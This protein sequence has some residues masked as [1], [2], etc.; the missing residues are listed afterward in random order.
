MRANRTT[1]PTV[2]V[3][4]PT[5]NEAEN[6][7][8]VLPRIPDVHEVIVVDGHSTDGS[9]EVARAVRPSARV[10]QQT[11]RGKGNAMACGFTAATGQVLVM[12]DADGSAD[13]DEIPLFVEALTRGYDYAKGTRYSSGGGSEDLTFLRS[14]GNLFLNSVSNA[15][16]ATRHTDLCY[17]YNAFWRDLLPLLDLPPVHGTERSWGDG[18]EIEAVIA[19]RMA[20]HRVRTAEVPSV[21]LNR[22]H[23]ESKLNPVSDGLRILRTITA[24]RFRTQR[25][26]PEVAAA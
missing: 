16:F 6:L 20:A 2:S 23:G 7:E 14:L 12:F 8:L 19:C 15:L 13:P 26:L 24:E 21:E 17:G 9:A 10:M 4:V 5:R 18:F 11:R 3:I 22:I 1:D 25:Q